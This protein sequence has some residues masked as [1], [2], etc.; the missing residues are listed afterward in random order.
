LTNLRCPDISIRGMCFCRFEQQQC[1]PWALSSVTQ[2]S[3]VIMPITLTTVLP[4]HCSVSHRMAAHW[5]ERWDGQTGHWYG[6]VKICYFERKLFYTDVVTNMV[7]LYW[8]VN[9]NSI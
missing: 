7:H 1:L 2:Q 6:V 8:L 9:S 5:S 4:W 3:E